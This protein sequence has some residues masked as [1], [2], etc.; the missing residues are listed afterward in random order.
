MHHAFK[1]RYRQPDTGSE[2]F[3]K[4]IYCPATANAV[5]G[6]V[7][8]PQTYFPLS[9]L[10]HLCVKKNLSTRTSNRRRK[11]LRRLL[12]EDFRLLSGSA[13][14]FFVLK[15]TTKKR[16]Q[17]TTAERVRIRL[18]LQQ[19][20]VEDFRNLDGIEGGTLEKLVAADKDIETF[21]VVA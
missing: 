12:S 9:C 6:G 3:A 5:T 7:I 20:L 21:L 8:F 4:R 2:R 15:G 13:G 16:V 14:G 1:A 10:S 11:K 17:G 18:K 19:L